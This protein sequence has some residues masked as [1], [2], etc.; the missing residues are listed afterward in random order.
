MCVP[1]FTLFLGIRKRNKPSVHQDYKRTY[2]NGRED[3]LA[4]NRREQKLKVLKLTY[5][6]NSRKKTKS[7]Q[8]RLSQV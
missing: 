5:F 6:D 3:K 8:C 2:G 7:S 4:Q 1:G